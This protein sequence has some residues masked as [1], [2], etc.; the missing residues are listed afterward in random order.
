MLKLAYEYGAVY[1][2]KMATRV[3]GAVPTGYRFDLNPAWESS[4]PQDRQV[5]AREMAERITQWLKQND[6]LGSGYAQNPEF[7]RQV[8]HLGRLGRLAPATVDPHPSQE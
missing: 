1:A 3:G 8:A 4:L 7:A 5:R 6:S 2:V